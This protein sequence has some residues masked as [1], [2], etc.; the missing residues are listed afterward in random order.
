M[1]RV[2]YSGCCC[3]KMT[4]FR[5]KLAIQTIR[6]ITNHLRAEFRLRHKVLHTIALYALAIAI[7][8][9]TW[10]MRASVAPLLR[11]H[12]RYVFFFAAIAITSWCAGFGPSIV[13]ILLSYV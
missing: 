12:H 1:A 6:Q 10:V 7:V 8:A 2:P 11:D 3:D 5:A 9:L 4:A 13:A